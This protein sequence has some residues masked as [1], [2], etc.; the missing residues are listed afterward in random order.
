MEVTQGEIRPGTKITTIIVILIDVSH[1]IGVAHVFTIS[2]LFFKQIMR[3]CLFFF[4][5]F[6]K[7]QYLTDIPPITIVL[8]HQLFS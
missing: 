5:L 6:T 7:L 4:Y 3:P 1:L 8:V 2:P